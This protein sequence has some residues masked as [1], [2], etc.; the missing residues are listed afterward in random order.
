MNN[1]QS[2]KLIIK[3]ISLIIGMVLLISVFFWVLINLSNL[4]QIILIALI[5]FIWFLF[6][7]LGTKLLLVITQMYS[8]SYDINVKN[9]IVEKHSAKSVLVNEVKD[10]LIKDGFDKVE[11]ITCENFHNDEIY[12]LQ[13]IKYNKGMYIDEFC[14]L[15]DVVSLEQ[16]MELFE[17]ISKNSTIKDVGKKNPIILQKCVF[18]CVFCNKKNDVDIRKF[19]TK[20]N[21][22]FSVFVPIFIDTEVGEV[23]YNKIPRNKR[24]AKGKALANSQQ[25]ILKYLCK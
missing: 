17:E 21:Y 13:R 2:K 6:I 16:G 20:F 23:Y 19:I 11:L 12:Y 25:L 22:I 3:C 7:Y 18:L 9:D 24:F 4:E 14:F 10:K 15:K 1:F 8:N 5:A